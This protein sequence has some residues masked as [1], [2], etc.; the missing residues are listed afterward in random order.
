MTSSWQH[1]LF[2]RHLSEIRLVM[3]ASV[4]LCDGLKRRRRRRFAVFRE[5]G[6][7]EKDGHVEL[8]AS[9]GTAGLHRGQVIAACQ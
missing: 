1:V 2:R 7:S 6:V 4:C 3:K 9:K 5:R 8:L